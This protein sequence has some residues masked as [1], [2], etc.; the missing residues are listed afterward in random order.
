MINFSKNIAVI[1][2]FR[3]FRDEE[4]FIPKQIIKKAGIKIVN[5]SNSLGKALGAEGGEVTV[6]VSLEK[7]KVDNFDGVVFIGGPGALKYL[8]NEA[9]YLIIKEVV[10]KNKLLAALCIAPV[11]LARAGVL[12]NKKATVWSSSLDKSAIRILKENKVEYQEK[13]VVIEGRIITGSGPMAAKEFGES[14]VR[15]LTNK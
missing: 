7:L 8:D 14:V 12:K 6:D 15:G 9:S 2:A 1:I 11:I 3:D 10:S 13:S 4:Y 5:V